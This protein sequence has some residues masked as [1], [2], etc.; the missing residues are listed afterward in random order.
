MAETRDDTP[1]SFDPPDVRRFVAE[2]EH[3]YEQRRRT[4]VGS[5]SP[6]EDFGLYLIGALTNPHY[7]TG[8]EALKRVNEFVEWRRGNE[9]KR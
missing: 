9:P 7:S 4:H 1:N 3:S 6:L 8:Q 5:G 2:V